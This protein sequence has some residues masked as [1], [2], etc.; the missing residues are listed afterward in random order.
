MAATLGDETLDVK[1]FSLSPSP[2]ASSI[3]L[4]TDIRD[5]DERDDFKGVTI[6]V[7]AM[8]CKVGYFSRPGLPVIRW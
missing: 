8:S 5:L 6:G 4:D 1:S 2:S 7:C 3:I